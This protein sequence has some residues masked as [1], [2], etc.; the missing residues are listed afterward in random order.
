MAVVKV[1][2]IDKPLL[3]LTLGFRPPAVKASA[4]LQHS[5][6]VSARLIVKTTAYAQAYDVTVND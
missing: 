2:S 1:P 4:S 5:T 6:A 3:L